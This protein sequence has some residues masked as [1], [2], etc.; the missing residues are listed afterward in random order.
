[1]SSCGNPATD[2]DALMERRAKFDKTTDCIKCKV[3]RGSI[4]VRHA[5]YCKN[6]FFAVVTHKF[7]RSLEHPSDRMASDARQAASSSRTKSS[8]VGFSGGLGS[9]VLLDAVDRFYFPHEDLKKGGKAH[10]R[11]KKTSV[12]VHMCYVEMCNAFTGITDRT[13]DITDACKDYENLEL[14]I[15][16]LEDAFDP[17]WWS[18][19]H[20]LGT[21]IIP[22]S[23]IRLDDEA[24][25]F[26]Q[27]I[28]SSSD[29][30]S[31]LRKYLTSLPTPTA[32]QSA[33]KT[34]VRVILL[35]T[36]RFLRCS[37]VILGTSLTSLSINLISSIAQGGG[38]NVPEESYEE[39]T[40]S[41]V[42]FSAQPT[43]IRVIR[44]LRDI[45]MKECSAWAWWRNLLIIGKEKLPINERQSIGGLT[46]EFIIG[47]EKDYPSTVSAI[48]RTCAKVNPKDEATSRCA[49]CQR[50]HPSGAL[51]WK[52]RISIRSLSGDESSSVTDSNTHGDRASG[53]APDLCY[54]CYSHFVSRSSKSIAIQGDSAIPLPTWVS[55]SSSR[56]VSLERLKESIGEYL[57][58]E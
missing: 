18:K 42:D 46:E 15:C 2:P 39:W 27:S 54:A 1:M 6:C 33:I 45:G 30:V 25:P 34:M 38:F 14:H 36:A 47:L 20:P 28:E 22:S 10:P 3:E 19:F 4:V 53:L 49:V 51:D 55:N 11:N 12:K 17:N 32:V 40:A 13:S 8:L 23:S 48:A 29:P 56:K 41:S 7:R 31:N 43:T 37:Q 9:T 57:L 21:N 58:E 24:L 50:P 44:P 52:A 35:Y 26:T 5:V 16:R